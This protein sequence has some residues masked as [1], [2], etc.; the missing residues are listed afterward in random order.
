MAQESVTAVVE[1]VKRVTTS[2]RGLGGLLIPWAAALG[3]LSLGASV[4]ASVDLSGTYD[5]ATL[6]P[7]ERPKMFGDKRF[8]TREEAARISREDA[9]LKEAR[10]DKSDPNRSAPPAGGD[11]SS[12]AAGNVGGYNTFWI[13]NGSAAFELDGKFRTSI[14]TQPENGRRPELTAAAK[15]KF[16]QLRSKR[17]NNSGTAW[18]QDA[19]GKGAGPYDDMELRPLAE[20]CIL[21]FGPTAGPPIFPTLYNNL[22]RIVQTKDSIMILAEM[23]HDARI[24]RLNSEHRPDHVRTWLGDSIGYWEGDTLVVETKNF[25]TRPG[26]YGADE[27]LHVTERFRRL[28]D[29]TLSYSF[30]VDNPSVWSEPWGGEYPWPATRDKVYEYA[31]HEGNYALGNI[32]RGARL[33]EA[34]ALQAA[35]Q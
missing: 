30:T 27:N 15:T 20:R 25:T 21:G 2:N 35:A 4:Q 33:L 31:C 6:T 17:R 16:A 9:A 23:V 34:E 29:S 32:M 10:N 5:V 18:W 3:A 14:L 24:V 28:D 13:D 26:L 7:L 19:Q 1:E 22:K 11:G 12:G 8:L